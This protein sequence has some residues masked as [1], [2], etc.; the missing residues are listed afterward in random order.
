MFRPFTFVSAGQI[1]LRQFVLKGKFQR[2]AL[3]RKPGVVTAYSSLMLF[4]SLELMVQ[5]L[6]IVM[7]MAFFMET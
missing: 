4:I 6:Y 7:Q 2:R 5:S 3:A 1:F